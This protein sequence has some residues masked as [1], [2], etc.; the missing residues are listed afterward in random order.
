[1]GIKIK[2]KVRIRT[3]FTAFRMGFKGSIVSLVCTEG[4][5]RSRDVRSGK[6]GGGSGAL[7][8]GITVWI[9]FWGKYRLFYG[10]ESHKG[11][12]EGG[13]GSGLGQGGEGSFLLWET[14]EAGAWGRCVCA[15]MCFVWLRLNLCGVL[16]S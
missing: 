16:W 13:R 7:R 6:G 10:Y 14:R 9:K 3:I 8:L 12:L 4:G 5:K 11:A 2:M 15:G 1:M